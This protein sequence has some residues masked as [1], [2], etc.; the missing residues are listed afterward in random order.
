[1]R[2]DTIQKIVAVVATFVFGVAIAD[3]IGHFFIR[4]AEERGWYDHPSATADTI[5]NYLSAVA[6]S[7]WFHWIGGAV[8]GFAVGAWL[9]TFLR[10]R[11][12]A[13]LIK[14]TEADLD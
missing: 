5:M 10:R 2:W 11:E 7:P 13:P 6:A 3:P 9:D 8:I 4:W 12:R 14:K 1:M